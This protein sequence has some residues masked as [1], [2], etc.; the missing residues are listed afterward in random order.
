MF[1]LR[2][3]GKITLDQEVSTVV[4]S[5][6]P[7]PYPGYSAVS[8]QLLHACWE[9]A[10]SLTHAAVECF[11]IALLDVHCII[12]TLLLFVQ[13]L[14][15]RVAQHFLILVR[16]KLACRVSRRATSTTALLTSHKSFPS[17]T[18]THSFTHLAPR[19]VLLLLCRQSRHG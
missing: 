5:Y 15:R 9:Q 7:K 14:P 4:P 6:Q 10:C 1:Q 17:A 12:E 8:S 3:A 11:C 18:H 2:D 19:F 13:A 16:I